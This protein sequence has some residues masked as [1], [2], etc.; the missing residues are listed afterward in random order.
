MVSVRS[1]GC[2][3]AT[4]L[5]VSYSFA[6]FADG[7]SQSPNFL[8]LGPD[9]Q[10]SD[11][12]RM[13][14]EQCRRRLAI[15]WLGQ[16]LPTGV[17]RT[18]VC[19]STT[20]TEASGG[21]LPLDN[22]GR[23]LHRIRMNTPSAAASEQ[24][25]AHEVT[26]LVMEVAFGG[27]LPVWAN[28]GVAMFADGHH[29]QDVRAGWIRRY[30]RSGSWPELQGVITAEHIRND[31]EAYAVADY[32]TQ[33]L[34]SLGD[35]A[36][37]FSFAV[38]GNHAGWETAARLW[39]GLPLAQLQKGWQSWAGRAVAGKEMLT[40]RPWF[41]SSRPGTVGLFAESPSRPGLAGLPARRAP[42]TDSALVVASRSA[43]NW[44][45]RGGD[46]VAD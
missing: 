14:A 25:L 17:G 27:E 26:H 46:Q 41:R 35:R 18:L 20:A 37:F 7:L 15:H 5:F 42:R 34:L 31:I 6:V 19:V 36:T 33:Y 21:F 11:E 39:Y 43:S 4:I 40:H 10:T 2:V 8:V 45:V 24:T 44:P 29:L 23:K 38:E 9:Q 12:V 28:E 16:E 30:A 3:C 32:L 22:S 13:R 1:F